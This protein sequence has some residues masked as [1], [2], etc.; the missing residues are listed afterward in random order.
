MCLL[1]SLT[2]EVDEETRLIHEAFSLPAAMS[3]AQGVDRVGTPRRMDPVRRT[4]VRMVSPALRSALLTWR[5]LRLRRHELGRV[6][7][8]AGSSAL[9][10]DA[11]GTVLHENAAFARLISDESPHDVV[12]LREAARMLASAVGAR[13]QRTERTAMATSQVRTGQSHYELTATH[14]SALL[15]AEPVI[16]VAIRRRTSA[17]LTNDELRRRF[18]LTP[19][20]VEVARLVGEGL[21]NQE[22]AARLQVSF[23]TARNHV[24]RVLSKL[25]VG[26]R[27][28]VGTLLRAE[29]A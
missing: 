23:F 17:P 15:G 18:G 11:R 5:Q 6:L 26:N 28:R 2:H 25:G 29:A 19:R 12:R 14:S 7:D 24:E 16:C 27:S 9:L 20:E 4:L 1:P 21:S 13:R 10:F 3:A 22:M 8:T